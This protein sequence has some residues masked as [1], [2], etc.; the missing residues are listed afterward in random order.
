MGA[1]QPEWVYT[2]Y[3][4]RHFPEP[5]PNVGVYAFSRDTI[6]PR[7]IELKEM[8]GKSLYACAHI[9][10]HQALLGRIPSTLR[11]AYISEKNGTFFFVFYLD[12]GF[13]DSDLLLL[14]QAAEAFIADFPEYII[15]MSFQYWPYPKKIPP[16]GWGI[17]KRKE[18]YTEIS[19]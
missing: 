18:P 13:D 7:Q 2:K 1:I 4:Q 11:S 17:F 16:S 8:V 5:L 3:E 12:E 9:S 10:G 19:S 6:L 14:K 15:H